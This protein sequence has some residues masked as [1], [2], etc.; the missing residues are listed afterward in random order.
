M[1]AGEEKKR[2]GGAGMRAMVDAGEALARRL[3]PAALAE[4]DFRHPSRIP[5]FY[6]YGIRVSCA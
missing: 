3:P 2:E 5:A 4:K 6:L 1:G